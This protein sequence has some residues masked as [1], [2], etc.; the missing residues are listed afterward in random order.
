MRYDHD[1]PET[2]LDAPNPDDILFEVT[3]ETVIGQVKRGYGKHTP[4]EAAFM[5]IANHEED[6]VFK[7]PDPLTFGKVTVTVT[8]GD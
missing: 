5:L 8:T 7:F 6:G 1:D 2:I 3:V 4:R